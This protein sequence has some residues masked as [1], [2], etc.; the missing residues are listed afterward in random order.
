MQPGLFV[1]LAAGKLQGFNVSNDML[2]RAMDAEFNSEQDDAIVTLAGTEWCWWKPP[3]GCPQPPYFSQHWH[4]S[5][6]YLFYLKKVGFIPQLLSGIN[7][8]FSVEGR[9]P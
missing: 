8:L 6:Q 7:V 9:W 3:V 5:L 4:P 2:D 1:Q